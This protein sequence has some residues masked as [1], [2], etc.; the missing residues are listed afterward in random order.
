MGCHPR[1]VMFNR[2]GVCSI[3]CNGAFKPCRR[4]NL[5]YRNKKIDQFGN[6]G[7]SK[8]LNE[9]SIDFHRTV[10]DSLFDQKSLVTKGDESHNF[11]TGLGLKKLGSCLW[12]VSIFYNLYK[13]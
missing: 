1:L 3:N 13:T 12:R 8:G 4:I 10:G 6:Y 2:F 7:F 9:R 5:N 11:K